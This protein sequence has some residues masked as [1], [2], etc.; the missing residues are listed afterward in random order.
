MTEQAVEHKRI[1][2]ALWPDEATRAQLHAYQQKLGRDPA[3]L[4]AL[5]KG[6]SVKPG[7]LHMTLH[8]IGSVSTEVLQN[9]TSAL[10]FVHANAFE[11]KVDTAGYFPRP[12]VLWLG[13]MQMPPALQSL[14]QQTAGCVQQCIEAYEFKSFQPH[15]SLFR[16]VGRPGELVQPPAIYWPVN[17]FALVESKTLPEGVQYEVLKQW[18]LA[19]LLFSE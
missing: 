18:P 13:V 16:K 17:S 9:L 5:Q 11:M 4:A 15:I 12:G 1:F 19:P 14:V 6:R 2:L 7:N 8:F 3:L 10:D